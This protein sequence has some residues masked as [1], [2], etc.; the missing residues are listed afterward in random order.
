MRL[1]S[2]R[3]SVSLC[4]PSNHSLAPGYSRGPL[5]GA[6]YVGAGSTGI[7][8]AGG[9]GFGPVTK[10]QGDGG[11][12]EVVEGEGGRGGWPSAVRPASHGWPTSFLK[13]DCAERSHRG[14]VKLSHRSLFPRPTSSFLLFHPTPH[15]SSPVTSLAT[16][17]LRKRGREE[18][19]ERAR[20]GGEIV[21]ER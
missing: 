15:H 19:R 10:W 9:G 12:M 6:R 17:T 20:G 2:S 1:R 5:G 4:L 16:L 8:G 14:G 21:E 7:G 3:V 18:K 11:V 13:A